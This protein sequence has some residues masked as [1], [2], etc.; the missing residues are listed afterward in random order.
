[1]ATVNT[2]DAA[3]AVLAQYIAAQAN[4][5]AR[6]LAWLAQMWARLTSYR[7]ADADAFI[8]AVVPMV[9]GAQRATATLTTAALGR[10]QAAQTGAPVRLPSVA[11]N[12]F[13]GERVRAA[14]PTV[15][16]RRPFVQVYTELADGKSLDAAA[17]AGGRRLQVIAA[18]DVQL[19]KTHAAQATLGQMDE[20][21]GYRR[22]LTGTESCGLCIV[23]ATQRYHKED[24]AAIHPGCDCEVAPLKPGEDIGQVISPTM[25]SDAHEAIFQRFG[26]FSSAAR[27]IG[28][29]V[30]GPDGKPLLYKDVLIVHQHGEIGPVLGVRGHHFDGPHDIK[31]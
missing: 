21:A 22:V 8:R 27:E 4:L 9:A 17:A 18:T 30:I 25:L 5:R 12:D 16:Y 15:V 24:L 23:A 26:K 29:K 6:L 2:A 20:V 10:V 1:M 19:A 31:S 3:D 14:D 7:D 11:P 13:T 28:S